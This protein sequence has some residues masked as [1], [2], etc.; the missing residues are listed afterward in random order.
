MLQLEHIFR[1]V[2]LSTCDAHDFLPVARPHGLVGEGL[3]ERQHLQEVVDCALAVQIRLPLPQG[4]GELARLRLVLVH[5]V[6]HLLNLLHHIHPEVVTIALNGGDDVDVQVVQSV[7][8]LH[9][10]LCLLQFWILR[11]WQAKELLAAAVV[12]P[13][14][15]A[16]LK[17][18]LELAQPIG[19][20]HRIQIGHHGSVHLPVAPEILGVHH[21]RLDLLDQL[22]LEAD[23]EARQVVRHI[24]GQ[25][26]QLLPTIPQIRHHGGLLL[27]H[28]DLI[29]QQQRVHLLNGPNQVVDLA[30]FLTDFL[31]HSH[32]PAHVLQ[33]LNL[34]IQLQSGVP[35]VGVERLE[36]LTALLVQVVCK[37][38][39]PGGSLCLEGGLQ[40]HRLKGQGADV[41]HR[42]YVADLCLNS[43]VL[44]EL[45]LKRL[46]GGAG[47]SEAAIH[48]LQVLFP[49]EGV[50][51][52]GGHVVVD[53]RLDALHAAGQP[54]DGLHDLLVTC[55]ELVVRL[56][57]GLAPAW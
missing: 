34:A 21:K 24:G 38:G 22:A 45:C 44:F 10:L 20:L 57:A 3:E 26:A 15:L 27:G 12:L 32:D 35:D 23:L 7:Q 50:L 40:R 53:L 42:S 51:I 49:Q 19:G 1:Q 16:D 9:L 6:R 29:A 25:L 8:H 13:L 31:E 56:H 36:V 48:G 43:H 47:G 30:L 41:V 33:V 54:Q 39:L 11:D 46:K 55:D 2:Q 4:F 37:L 5:G 14:A 17:H 28:T 52:K 18:L